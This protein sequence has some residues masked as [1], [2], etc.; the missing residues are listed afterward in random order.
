VRRETIV[1]SGALAQKAGQGGL[2]WV[3][4]QY[5][6]GLRRLGWDVL[7]VDWLDE[8]TSVDDHG[9]PCPIESS[10]GARYTTLVFEAFGLGDA[11]AILDRS[12]GASIGRSR[13]DVRSALRRSACLL[14]VMG[15]LD[16]GELLAAAPLRV[17]LDIDPGFGQ[18]W[19]ELGLHDPYPAHDRFVTVGANVGGAGCSVPTC[20]LD[21]I[22]TP[23]PV[24]LDEWPAAVGPPGKG[25]TTVASWRGPYGPVEYDGASYGLRVHEFRRFLDLP[26]RTRASFELALDIDEADRRDRE[27]LEANGWTLVDPAES[28]GDPWRYRAYVQA[29]TGELLVAKGMYVGTR[30]GWF[31]DRSI[32][33][34]ASGRPVVAQD[35]AFGIPTG[36]GLLSFSTT[37]EA[38][39]AVES[40]LAE[41]DRHARAARA[42]AEAW[43]DS[44]V[45]LARL[46]R[47]I[48]VG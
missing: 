37:D 34:L 29:S 45:V 19:Y 10:H 25:F 36:E 20:G 46:L 7:F 31:S 47:R 12:S 13:A 44:D 40:V 35:T 17:F 6:L 48:G 3:Y 1:V 26:R 30:S 39:G 23:Q 33:Y 18:M 38:A 9:V 14:N 24:V 27:A 32:C 2:T 11:F 41:P 5:L 15:Y 43:F 4:L 8:T 21:W 42:L 28:A 16:D 22:T